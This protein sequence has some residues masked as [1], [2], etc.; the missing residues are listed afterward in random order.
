VR[1]GWFGQPW[2]FIQAVGGIKAGDATRLEDGTVEIT[3]A[4]FVS[5]KT[6]VGAASGCPSAR[7]EALAAGDYTVSYRGSDREPH[8]IGRVK[9]P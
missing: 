1:D 6:R 2:D 8:D 3:L 4:L 7:F 5:I 9:V